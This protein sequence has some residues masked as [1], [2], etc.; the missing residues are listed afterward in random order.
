VRSFPLRLAA[1]ALRDLRD[2][3]ADAALFA[4][5]LVA[6]SPAGET[7]AARALR[8]DREHFTCHA[9]WQGDCCPEDHPRGFTGHGP[10]C[11]WE[12]CPLSP[13]DREVAV[14]AGHCFLIGAP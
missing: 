14:P 5:T 10:T 12:G 4:R 2:L 6:L 9:G 13:D 3:L 7:R 8:L 1:A 11:S